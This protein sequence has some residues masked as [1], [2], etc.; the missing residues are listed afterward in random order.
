ML[1]CLQRNTCTVLLLPTLAIAAVYIA[2]YS[3][4]IY[5][6]SYYTCTCN[7]QTYIKLKKKQICAINNVSSRNGMECDIRVHI[8]L[9]ILM[10]F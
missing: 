8:I 3:L 7:M 4:Y 9:H 6:H 2:I 1:Y 10:G 5:A